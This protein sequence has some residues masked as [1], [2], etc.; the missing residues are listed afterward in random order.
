MEFGKVYHMNI[1]D[2]IN[3]D[4]ILERNKIDLGLFD[5]NI[6][7]INI[8][9]IPRLRLNAVELTYFMIQNNAIN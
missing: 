9:T 2:I 1:N 4:E 5:K 3:F 8:D 7:E 6:K